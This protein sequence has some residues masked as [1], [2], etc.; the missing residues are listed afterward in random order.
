MADD[1][2]RVAPA[3]SVPSDDI[4]DCLNEAFSDYLIRMPNFEADSWPG[5]LH[6]QGVDLSLSRVGV[7]SEHVVAF[8]LVCPRS[9]TA[10]R[11]A[12][13][14]ARP[15]ARGSGIAPRLLD[16]TIAEAQSRGL[17]SIELEVFA[18]NERAFRLYQS[19]GLQPATALR[20]FD[21]SERCRSAMKP[22]VSVTHQE[23]AR[24]ARDI[25]ASSETPL[26]WQVCGDA[27]ERLPYVPHCWQFGTA[28]I[29]FAEMTGLVMVMSLLDGSPDYRA[30][31][32]LLGSL[33]ATYREA[34]LRAPQLHSDHGAA[35]AFRICGWGEVPLYQ[36]LMIRML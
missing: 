14:G 18:Q 11:V 12:V 9:A 23:A 35:H 3:T 33:R 31:A 15:S 17:R 1:D 20:G 13:M 5:F 28:Q 4:R 6:R 34:F 10:W 24:R 19:R 8:S 21:G 26:A 2:V 7:Q 36:N 29:V 22:V 16:E 30:A 32:D 25:E 27:I